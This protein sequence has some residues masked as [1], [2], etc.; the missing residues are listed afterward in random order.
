MTSPRIPLGFRPVCEISPIIASAYCPDRA[1]RTKERPGR[2]ISRMNLRTEGQG[3][4]GGETSQNE[5][6]QWRQNLAFWE[7]FLKLSNG[8]CM[9]IRKQCPAPNSTAGIPWG[10]RNNG[11]C[12]H[13]GLAQWLFSRARTSRFAGPL[14]ENTEASHLRGVE[15]LA[16]NVAAPPCSLLKLYRGHKLRSKTS[17]VQNYTAAWNVKWRNF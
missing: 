1:S 4:Q 3:H 5:F 16:L 14:S 9:Y 17:V 12:A 11:T 10:M 8:Q 13:T 15:S 6:L 7:F 2:I